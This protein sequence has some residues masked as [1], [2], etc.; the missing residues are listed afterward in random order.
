[1]ENFTLK[2]IIDNMKVT[3]VVPVYNAEKYI[4]RC[5]GSIINQSYTELEI[6]LVNDGSTDDS[7]LICES[8]AKED[9]RII[10]VNQH[11]TGPAKARNAGIKLAKGDYI[12]FVD[13]DDEIKVNYFESLVNAAK[14]TKAD[15]VISDIIIENGFGHISILK[16]SLPKNIIILQHDIKK[17][18]LQNY[19]GGELGNIPSLSNKLYKCSFIDK[20]NLLIDETRVRAEDY[21]FNFYAFCKADNCVAL[22]YAGYVYK[23]SNIGSVMKTFREN[24]FEN[25]LRTRNEL[26]KNNRDLN[27]NINY[28]IWDSEFINN[29]NEFIL[30]AIR[31]NRLDVVKKILKEEEF[32]K[33]MKN[34]EPLKTHTKLIKI[35]INYKF[36]FSAYIVYYSWSKKI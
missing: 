27:I 6:I 12:G 1:M 24:Q 8:L 4:K 13:A 31:N 26:L 29:T 34:F 11:N 25:F 7:H 14:I 22:D 35:L 17:M 28:A 33:A 3:I 23:V 18:I 15:V 10:V 20:N 2:K 19:Y 5:V 21:W 32:R 30:M 36:N 16:N 9:S